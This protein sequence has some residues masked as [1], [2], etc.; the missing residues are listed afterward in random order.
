MK[1]RKATRAVTDLKVVVV[2]IPVRKKVTK[3]VTNRIKTKAFQY[4]CCRVKDA[5]K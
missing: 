3:G 1:S 5:W 4:H 2:S